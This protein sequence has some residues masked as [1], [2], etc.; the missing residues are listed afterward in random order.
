M[1]LSGEGSKWFEMK[2]EL[3]QGYPLSPFFCSEYVMGLLKD[4]EERGLGIKVEGTC[5][6]LLLNVC[7]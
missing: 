3:G 7:R 4:L 1:L 6:G 2:A 5:G